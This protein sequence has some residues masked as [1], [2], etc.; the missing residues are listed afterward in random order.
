M[1]LQFNVNNVT[2]PYIIII[3]DDRNNDDDDEKNKINEDDIF[4]SFIGGHTKPSFDHQ[5]NNKYIKE[6]P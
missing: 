6:L 4:F 3:D 1:N 5:V 2:F